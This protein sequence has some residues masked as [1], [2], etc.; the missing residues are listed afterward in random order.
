MKKIFIAA[1]LAL[2]AIN[3]FSQDLSFEF[4]EQIKSYGLN[5]EMP[6]GYK[7]KE[8]IEN[9]D[10]QYSFAIINSDGSMEVRYS[11]FP[12][13]NYLLEHEKSKTQKNVIMTDPNIMYKGLMVTNG[14]NMTNG[15]M[16]SIGDFHVSAVK[17]EF[18]ADYGGVV[19]LEFNCEFGKGYKYGQFICLHKEN[20]TDVIVTFMSNDRY[21]HS[22]LMEIPFHA[23]TF[24]N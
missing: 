1:F 4:K 2:I 6:P 5:F 11:L 12:I 17:K 3:S 23:L 24:K 22:N 9:K 14:M 16:P 10:L 18:N 19:F 20:I 21:K 15:K 8:V 7:I 13:K